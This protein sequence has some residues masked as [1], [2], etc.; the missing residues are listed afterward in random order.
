M[1]VSGLIRSVPIVAE[2]ATRITAANI[3]ENATITDIN[4]YRVKLPPPSTRLSSLYF[5]N[6]GEPGIPLTYVR[7]ECTCYYG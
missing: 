4:Y 2:S 6:C 7:K 5:A 1:L 3:I